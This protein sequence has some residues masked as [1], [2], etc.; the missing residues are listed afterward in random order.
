MAVALHQISP[1][2]QHWPQLANTQLQ[3]KVYVDVPQHRINGE[4]LLA[5]RQ[6]QLQSQWQLTQQANQAWAYTLQATTQERPLAHWLG[7]WVSQDIDQWKTAGVAGFMLEAKGIWA[8]IPAQ[9]QQNWHWKAYVR[10]GHLQHPQAGL[11]IHLQA[12]IQGQSQSPEAWQLHLDTLGLRWEGGR[13]EA[14]GQYS[15][16]ATA[17]LLEDTQLVLDLTA[18]SL[19]KIWPDWQGLSG[20]SLQLQ[21]KVAGIWSDSILPQVQLQGRWQ[22]LQWQ[23]PKAVAWQQLS[24]RLTID[25]PE[26]D[27]SALQIDLAGFSGKLGENSFLLE[28]QWHNWQNPQLSYQTNGS[29][30]LTAL[31][32]YFGATASEGLLAWQGSGQGALKTF[33]RPEQALNI[34]LPQAKGQWEG[35]A[36]LVEGLRIQLWP[37]KMNLD[38]AQMLWQGYAAR[39]RLTILG[40]LPSEATQVNLVLEQ[41]RYPLPQQLQLFLKYWPS[42]DEEAI[43]IPKIK[44]EAAQQDAGWLVGVLAQQPDFFDLQGQGH[45]SNQQQVSGLLSLQLETTILGRLGTLA[46]A[47]YSGQ[48]LRYGQPATLRWSL[49]GTLQKPV[50]HLK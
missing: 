25:N 48:P 44:L 36:W 34:T 21:A 50:L 32:P 10:Q 45:I 16:Q 13:V 11:P 46:L 29:L 49:G 40:L 17:I 38:A 8:G 3:G 7:L 37:Q 26:P 12:E 24:G 43:I 1:V 28:A 5:L 31:L 22:Q 30:A 33:G 9:T 47:N 6:W 14:S 4:L 41:L 39:P 35:E 20:D 2:P 19:A 23:Q 27:G 15:Q 18:N 42:G